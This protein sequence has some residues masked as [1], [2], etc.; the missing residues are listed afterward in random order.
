MGLVDLM[1]LGGCGTKQPN[2]SAGQDPPA[3]FPIGLYCVEDFSP[4]DPHDP[5]DKMTVIDEQA[6]AHHSSSRNL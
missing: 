5:P 3:F 4:R 1:G 6:Y 2:V